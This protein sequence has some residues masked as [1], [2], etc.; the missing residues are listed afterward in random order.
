[1]ATRTPNKSGRKPGPSAPVKAYL[2]AYNLL[3][4]AAW[5]YVLLLTVNHLRTPGAEGSTLAKK[6]FW[7]T[8]VPAF[9][10][11]ALAPLYQRA[12]TAYAA[13]GD[14]TKYV[15]S[16]ALLEVLHVLLGLVRSP[17]PT[18]AMQVASRLFLVWGVADRFPAAQQSPFYASMVLSWAVTEVVRYPFYAAS[19]VGWE[20]RALLWLRYT[21][22]Y[23]LYITG[24]SSEAFANLATLPRST[25][26]ADWDAY[27]LFRG[28]MF[29]IWWPSLY[30][31]YTHMIKLRRKNFSGPGRTLGAKP[32]SQ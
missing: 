13:V 23:V 4:T 1:M 22:F 12:T 25:D 2:I 10:P 7:G 6:L 16:A 3:S 21:T 5:G 8:S 9:V 24:A 28:A 14:T 17:L 11:P 15:Q 32:K 19:L 18:T 30:V 20:P 26:L 27:A 31:L 29:A